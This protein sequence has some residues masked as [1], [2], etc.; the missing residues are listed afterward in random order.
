VI[1]A[2]YLDK[3]YSYPPCWL[4]VADVYQSELGL[5]VNDFA[6]VN[7]SVRSIASAFRIALH[8]AEHGFARAS[9]P[10]DYAVVLMSRMAGRTPTH[11]GI[12]YA[13]SVLHATPDGVVYQG[14]STLADI[15]K[16]IEYWVKS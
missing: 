15:Y 10:S 16:R 11:C 14:M 8:K 9:G 5:T 6:T 7:S 13:G 3:Q 2:D 12:Y 1:I 4:L